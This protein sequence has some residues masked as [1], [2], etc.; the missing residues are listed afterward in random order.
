MSQPDGVS[1][2]TGQT[3]LRELVWRLA[4]M[5]IWGLGIM[6]LLTLFATHWWLADLCANLRVQ[7]TIGLLVTSVLL[8]CFQKWKLV[9][10]QLMFVG[11]HIS[12]LASGFSIATANHNAVP[13]MTVTTANVYTGNRRYDDIE[14]ELRKTNADL[15]AV[16]ELSTGLRDHLAGDFSKTWPWSLKHPGD[17]GNFGIGLYS[18]H[19]FENPQVEFFNDDAIPSVSAT[20]VCNGQRVHILATHTLPPMGPRRFAHR[21]KH[22]KMVADEVRQRRQREPDVP[23]VVLGDLNLTPWSPVFSDFLKQSQLHRAGDGHGWT[24]TWYRFPSFPFGLV[25]DHVLTTNDVTCVA[26]T[27]GSDIGSDHRFVTAKLS[28]LMGE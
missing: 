25:L 20:I 14:A 13:W 27:V 2:P 3:H 6:S 12:W 22:L 7:W 28:L 16:V 1:T 8:A 15:I 4:V 19:P 18:K 10:L 23:L 9:V 11:L 17:H 26:H 24:P 21:N 5:C